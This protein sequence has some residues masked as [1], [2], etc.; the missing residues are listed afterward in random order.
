[1]TVTAAAPPAVSELVEQQQRPTN[2]T[3]NVNVTE[4]EQDNFTET[5][6]APAPTMRPPTRHQTGEARDGAGCGGRRAATHHRQGKSSGTDSN[7]ENGMA[8]LTLTAA[9]RSTATR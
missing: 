3:F 7:A 6:N 9:C 2:Q 8:T 1:M 4:T 5:D